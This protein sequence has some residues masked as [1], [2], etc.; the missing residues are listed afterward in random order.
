MRLALNRLN[1][2]RL[3]YIYLFVALVLGGCDQGLSPILNSFIAFNNPDAEVKTANETKFQPKIETVPPK[4]LYSRLKEF[5]AVSHNKENSL[6]LIAVPQINLA[7]N[8]IKILSSESP[9]TSI[10]QVDSSAIS[11]IPGLI[12]FPED[13]KDQENTRLKERFSAPPP[14]PMK[15]NVPRIGVLLPLS[16]PHSAI[17]EALLNAAQLALF[18]FS[19]KQ[20]EL[21]PQDTMGTPGGASDAVSLVIG[22][23]ASLILGPLF[24]SSVSAITPAA[25]AANI[26]VISFSNDRRVASQNILTMGFPPHEQVNRIIRFAHK[27]GLKKF[28]LLAP[29]N[30]YGELIRSALTSAADQLGAEVTDTVFFDPSDTDFGPKSRNAGSIRELANYDSRRQALIDE[31]RELKNREDQLA[32]NTLKRLKDLQTLGDPPFEALLLADGGKHLQAIAA[33]LPFYDIDPKK[34]RIL[35]LAQWGTNQN[36]FEPA[37]I[38]SW[39]AA[40]PI[41]ERSDFVNNYKEMFGTGAPPRLATLSYDATALASVLLRPDGSF[42]HSEILTP[43]GF[44]GRDGIFRFTRDG[45]AQHGLSIYKIITRGIRVI[46]MAPNH[47]GQ[48]D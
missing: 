15:N 19:E 21:L 29:S 2:Q 48:L 45:Y 42:D 40:P 33:L 37:L 17:G 46:E 47:F 31:R 43:H 24:A 16:G 3:T 5:P 10:S 26:P 36:L 39:F 44:S 8:N 35:G 23:G 1:I 38:G 13:L 12:E 28:A 34:I 7:P 32:I 14:P 20:F 41:D 6:S 27:K 4:I 22:D 9:S 30:D 18:H 11:N 25:L